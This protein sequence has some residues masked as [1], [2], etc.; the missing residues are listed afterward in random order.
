MAAASRPVW[1]RRLRRQAIG[2]GGLED[3]LRALRISLVARQQR[4]AP[5]GSKS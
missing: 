4:Q 2:E 1:A 3:A 5:T